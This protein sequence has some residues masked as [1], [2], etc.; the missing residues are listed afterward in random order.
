MIAMHG[1]QN[2]ICKK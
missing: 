2:K 1:L